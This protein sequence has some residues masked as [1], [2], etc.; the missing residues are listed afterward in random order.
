MEEGQ[1]NVVYLRTQEGTSPD[2]D[3]SADFTAAWVN[4]GVGSAGSLD[5]FGVHDRT[6]EPDGTGQ[7]TMGTIGK[8]GSGP[9]NFRLQGMYQFGERKGIEVSAYM[10]A[11]SGSLDVMDGRGRVTLWY[12]YL[13]GDDELGD[14]PGGEKL[15]SFS[16]LYGA[17]H[18]Y[19]GRADY[20]LD[21]PQDTE[22]LGLTDAALKLTY[23]PTSLLRL[24]LDV[25]AFSTAQQGTLSSRAL[26]KEVD[27]WAQYRF[28]A[29]LNLEAGY[30]VTWAGD[31]MEQLDR[32]TGTGNAAYL[33][34]SFRF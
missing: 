30:S 20:F 2:H 7:T 1:V 31:A 21:I 14:D 29:V 18:R 27:F 15:G 9:L 34:S 11:G 4:F 32:L 28:R 23:S 12:D 24:N 13:S 22:N 16:T 10:V 8:A 6:G 19:Y 26:A 3:F 33:M 17:R 5:F 25:H